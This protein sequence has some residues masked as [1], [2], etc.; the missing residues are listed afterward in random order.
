MGVPQYTTTLLG[1]TGTWISRCTLPHYLG[2]VGGGTLARYHHTGY[3]QSAMELLVPIATMPWGSG[4]WDSCSALP[5]CMGVVGNG[6]HTTL[7]QWSLLL[8]Y[9]AALPRGSGQW[10]SRDTLPHCLGEH[11]SHPVACVVL[12]SHMWTWCNPMLPIWT[13][14]TILRMPCFFSSPLA[15]LRIISV[16]PHPS[17]RA[18]GHLQ[19]A[20]VLPSR[21]KHERDI[22]SQGLSGSPWEDVR[23]VS[24]V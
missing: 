6:P 17:Y 16:P 19:H 2:A 8:Q 20:P 9:N 12:Q 14:V 11:S 23:S 18:C 3:R 24:T 7:R 13:H 5:H 22:F 4:Q 10:N 1:A 15:S 21:K